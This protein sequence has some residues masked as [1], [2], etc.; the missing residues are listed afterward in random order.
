[1]CRGFPVDLDQQSFL[2]FLVDLWSNGLTLSRN[3]SFTFNFLYIQQFIL[4]FVEPNRIIEGG[5]GRLQ[6]LTTFCIQRP[7]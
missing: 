4:Y 6:I 2:R 3:Y 5:T 1:M 7:H